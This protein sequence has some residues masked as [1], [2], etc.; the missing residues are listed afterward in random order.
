M[1]D[2]SDTSYEEILN[3][4]AEEYRTVALLTARDRGAHYRSD[5]MQCYQPAM[6]TDT[7]DT[8][9]ARDTFCRHFLVGLSKRMEPGEILRMATATAAITIGRPGISKDTPWGTEIII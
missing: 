3:S 5:E 7:I 6:K 8:I 4:V 9:G 2:S 1:V